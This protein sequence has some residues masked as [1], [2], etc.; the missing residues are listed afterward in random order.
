MTIR[1]ANLP[2]FIDRFSEEFAGCVIASLIDFFFNY[3]QIKL[4]KK[5]KDLTAFHTPIGLLRMIT[6]PQKAINSVV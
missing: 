5:N 1:N 2:P 4:D 6:L 3:D